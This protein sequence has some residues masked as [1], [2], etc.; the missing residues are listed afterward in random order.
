MADI[1]ISYRSLF[2]APFLLKSCLVI[3]LLGKSI[4]LSAQLNMQLVGQLDYEQKVNDVWGY[5]TEDGTEYALVGTQTGTSVVS[6]ADPANPVELFFV[7]GTSTTWRDMDT[8]G[9][10]G[11]VV[12][13]NCEDGLLVMDLS[14]LPNSMP[15][16]FWNELPNTTYESAHTI[17]IDEFGYGYLNGT[18][19]ESRRA[20]YVDLFSNPGQVQFAGYGPLDYAHDAYVRDNIMYAAEIYDGELAIY[21]VSDKSNTVFLGSQVTPS[22]FTHNTW[23]SDD[24]KTV[25]TTDEKPMSST[26]AYDINDFSD[27]KILDRFFSESS[28]GLEALPHNVYVKNDYLVISHYTDGVVIVDAQYPDNLVEVAHY[29]TYPN[30]DVGS[31]GCWSAYPFLPSGLVLASDR[32]TG[33]YVLTADYNRASYLKG[34]VTDAVTGANLNQV[35]VTVVQANRSTTTDGFGDYKTGITESGT[36]DVLFRLQFYKNKIISASFTNNQL[37]VVDAE[38][39]PAIN[40]TLNGQ[41]KDALSGAGIARAK[42]R[43][44]SE[45]YAYETTADDNGNY[46]IADFYSDEY[47]VTAGQW[48]Y[49]TIL[50]EYNIEATNF[51]ISLNQG[52]ED[53]FLLDLGWTVSGGGDQGDW[54]R[55][56]SEGALIVSQSVPPA[57]LS[58]SEDVAEDPGNYCYVTGN[59]G[60]VL[61]VELIDFTRLASPIIDMRTWQKPMV[62]FYH[63]FSSIV[64]PYISSPQNGGGYLDFKIYNGVDTVLIE[65][66][67]SA[68]ELVFPEWLK[69]EYV[70][71]DFINPTGQMQFIFEAQGGSIDKSFDEAAIDY[72]RA[73]DAEANNPPNESCISAEIYPNPYREAFTLEYQIETLDDATFRVFDAIGKELLAANLESVAG[74]IELG[75]GWLSGVYFLEIKCGG[76]RKSFVLIRQ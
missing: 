71:L 29:D 59:G 34:K 15:Y 36:F 42:L 35:Q 40:F 70:I 23:L 51:D 25:F 13:D 43:F 67:D 66:W 65:R 62:S 55:A 37:T 24:S 38:L 56:I 54:V 14:D 63:W 10:Y 74:R 6:L 76:D 52:Y 11:F 33:L 3:L 49:K 72:F 27:I 61:D 60:P 45:F 47:Q 41:V 16:Y 32:Q 48:A 5:T 57:Y 39:E 50:E 18:N 31:N 20:V 73:W 53:N 26:T 12:C 58:P 69:S 21:D 2:A 64:G 4:F 75:A 7:E 44:E 1:K 17:F 68:E 8:W 30:P 9:H 19:L 28:I 22:S 46:T